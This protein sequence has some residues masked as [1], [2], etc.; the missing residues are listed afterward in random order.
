[1]EFVREQAPERLG[2]STDAALGDWP[3]Y[4]RS[5]TEARPAI[6]TDPQ[7][8][9]AQIRTADLERQS[10]RLPEISR[11][12]EIDSQTLDDLIK[13]I[14]CKGT[15]SQKNWPSQQILQGLIGRIVRQL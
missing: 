1:M 14:Q 11:K 5:H 8:V 2:H 13:T 12:P 7:T 9:K 3:G 6:P 10:E 4:F 15:G